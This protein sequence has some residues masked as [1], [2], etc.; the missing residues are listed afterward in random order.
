MITIQKTLNSTF[1]IT[2]EYIRHKCFCLPSCFLPLSGGRYSEQKDC[3]S[4]P[5]INT[6][7][8]YLL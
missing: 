8:F 1:F 4:C 3:I 6:N 2:C 5:Y 7:P